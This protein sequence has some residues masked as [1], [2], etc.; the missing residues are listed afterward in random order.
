M[1][2]VSS[3]SG[4]LSL[5]DNLGQ[6]VR[7][8]AGRL[9]YTAFVPPDL[10]SQ[11]AEV[12][13]AAIA[14]ARRGHRLGADAGDEFAAWARLRLIDNDYA[15]LRKFEGRSSLR[16][17]LITVVQRLFLDWRNAEWGKWRPT[18]DARRGGTLAIELERLIIRD[19]LSYGEAV[20]TLLAR[21]VA[22]SREACEAA[23]ASLP[24]RPGRKTTDVSDLLNIPAPGLASDQVMADERRTRA[25][26]A[27]TVMVQALAMLPPQDQLILRLRFHDGFTVARIAVHIQEDQK[28]LYRRFTRLLG[29]VRS[30]M[31][32]GGVSADDAADLLAHPAD[33]FQPVFGRESGDRQN[34]PSRSISGGEEHV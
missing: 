10:Y 19:Q 27:R 1:G 13:E 12:I 5:V 22:P 24:Q 28:A 6:P 18:A 21:A 30:F 29:I 2:P 8:P 20:E 26:V 34:R 16:T 25:K 15:I 23:W 17:F 3:L 33:D 31:T 9:H 32:A 7:A 4:V 11:N 14:Y